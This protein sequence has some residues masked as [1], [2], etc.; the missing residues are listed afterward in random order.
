MSSSKFK[1]LK[2]SKN[3][4]EQHFNSSLFG[5]VP[6][7]FSPHLHVLNVSHNSFNK[8][9]IQSFSIVVQIFKDLGH[10]IQQALGR[11]LARRPGC[12]GSGRRVF[13]T[14]CRWLQAS[15]AWLTWGTGWLASWDTLPAV[16]PVFSCNV[17]APA[18]ATSRSGDERAALR[19][20]PLLHAQT[21]LFLIPFSP[22][23]HVHFVSHNY[24][25]NFRIQTFS[26]TVQKF[27]ENP[28]PISLGLSGRP[29]LL[30]LA[31]AA[32]YLA[33]AW[34]S[35][36]TGRLCLANGRRGVS[37]AS[38]HAPDPSTHQIVP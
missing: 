2:T 18:A 10:A 6:I 13:A 30:L 16:C 35:L 33:A 12:P 11:A 5:L 38:A 24:F 26:N 15:S 23:H 14:G 21:E 34:P 22:N 3:S 7:I 25:S 4:T 8:F 29:A 20:W 27:E 31:A 28:L 9:G 36:A 37:L 19:H 1:W 17:Q 32:L